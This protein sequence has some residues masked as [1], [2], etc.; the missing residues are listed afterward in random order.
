MSIS[1]AEFGVLD[2]PHVALL[3]NGVIDVFVTGDA[4][5][6]AGFILDHILAHGLDGGAI[7]AVRGFGAGG[8]EVHFRGGVD[9][10]QGLVVGPGAAAAVGPLLIAE[11]RAALTPGDDHVELFQLG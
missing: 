10:A 8:D 7:E 3:L 2:A 5:A 4:A 11:A 1:D 9:R 6:E